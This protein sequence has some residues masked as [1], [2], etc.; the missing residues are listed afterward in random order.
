M[1]NS[2]QTDD[3]IE[4]KYNKN[5]MCQQLCSASIISLIYRYFNYY[6]LKRRASY[7]TLLLTPKLP[8]EY[9]LKDGCYYNS[10]GKITEWSI[11]QLEFYS[12]VNTQHNCTKYVRFHIKLAEQDKTYSFDCPLAFA[13][14]GKAL[15][16]F[17]DYQIYALCSD[18]LFSKFISSVVK[19]SVFGQTTAENY[20]IDQG[21]L[22]LPNGKIVF[23]LG[24]EVVSASDEDPVISESTIKLKKSDNSG[25]FTSYLDKLINSSSFPPAAFIASLVA[26]V[27]PMFENELDEYG[28]T[29]F[30]YADSGLGKTEFSKLLS[31]I[32]EDH[33]N[34]VSLS[35]DKY[36]IKKAAKLKDSLIVIDDLNRTVSSR[37]RNSNEAKLCDFIQMNQSSGNCHYKDI[38]VKLDNIAIVTAEYVIKNNST[39]NRCLLV[40]LE[41]AF[42]SDELTL[43]KKEHGKYIAFLK[44]FILWLCRNYEKI[45]DESAYYK[46]KND[47]SNIGNENSGKLKRIMRTYQI[48][49]V[50]LDIFKRY[51]K[52]QHDLTDEHIKDLSN[53]CK[54]SIENCIN[55]TIDH[56][57]TDDNKIGREFINEILLGIYQE[58]I[59]SADFAEY[60]KEAKKARKN[61]YLQRYVFYFDGSYLCVE[62]DVLTNW[63]KTRLELEVVPSKQK[64][65]AQLRYYGLL[66]VIGGEYTSTISEDKSRKYYQLYLQRLKECQAEIANISAGEVHYW[67]DGSSSSSDYGSWGDNSN[68][69][70]ENIDDQEPY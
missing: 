1:I 27:K 47:N 49:C 25:D 18:N 50:T 43:L 28:F 29:I 69:C 5:T 21:Y 48:L 11:M 8:Q 31:D 3:L 17:F 65:S 16:I 4:I 66:K 12:A 14:E 62:A 59:V 57:L 20:A 53:I 64:V 61:K 52:E 34:I 42:D 30:I 39:I 35:S 15:D 54:T 36:A 44:D 23:G 46:S 38:E 10:K 32:F 60:S 2:K 51:L 6:L 55:D 19:L 13:I 70:F 63:L 56:C 40:Q 9:I 41:N 7:E 67:W 24:N 68:D 22:K 33:D 26:Y 45:S 37:I 58:D